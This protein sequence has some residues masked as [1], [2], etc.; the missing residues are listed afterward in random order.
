MIIYKKIY[1]GK[2][3]KLSIEL[4]LDNFRIN[5]FIL[6]SYGELAE[7]L[8]LFIDGYVDKASYYCNDKIIIYGS[9]CK[10]YMRMRWQQYMML[11]IN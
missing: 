6:R 9:L 8:N 2:G 11:I 1:I 3:N 10:K 5:K 4:E 7:L